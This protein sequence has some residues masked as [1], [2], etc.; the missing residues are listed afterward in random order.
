MKLYTAQ[1]RYS[2]NDRIDITVKGQDPIGKCFAPTWKMVMASKEKRLSWD[3]YKQKYKN[4]MQKSYLQN[5]HIW[6][7][8]LNRK[9]VT[10]VCFCKPGTSCHRYLLAD[11]FEKIGAAYMGERW[12]QQSI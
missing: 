2:G 12:L 7:D 3:E 5:Y 6:N 11:Y 9:E 4:L 8:I 1:Y 10:L